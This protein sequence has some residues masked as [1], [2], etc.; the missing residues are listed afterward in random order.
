MRAAILTDIISPYRIPVFNRLAEYDDLAL[1]VFFLAENSSLRNWR[2]EKERIRFKYE[3][4]PGRVVS[5]TYQ[6]GS[7]FFNP[8]ISAKISQGRFDSVLFGGYHHPSYWLALAYCKA[9]RKQTILWSERTC[10]TIA[11]RPKYERSSSACLSMLLIDTWCQGRRIWI[12]SRA[13]E[14]SEKKS[15]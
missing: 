7:L 14:S 4:L 8:T 12:I 9:A 1:E 6:N 3:V 11:S 15:G 13:L 2:V 5:K 10:V